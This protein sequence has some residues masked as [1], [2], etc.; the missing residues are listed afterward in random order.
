MGEMAKPDCFAVT[1]FIISFIYWM[2]IINKITVILMII[3]A[4]VLT[5][6]YPKEEDYSKKNNNDVKEKIK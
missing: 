2:D 6:M 4:I 1:V 5:V 3:I